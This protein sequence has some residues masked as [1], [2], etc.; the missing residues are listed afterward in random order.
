VPRVEQG[1]RD[2]PDGVREVHDPRVRR[3][4]R[5]H[6]LGDLEDDGHRAHRLR[7]PAC[8]C[9]LLADAA[10]RERDRLVAQPRRLA[11]DPELQEDERGVRDRRVEVVGDGQ[12]AAKALALKHAGRHLPDHGTSLAVDVVQDEL[13][14]GNAVALPRETRDE[15]RRVR[16]AAPDHGELH[17]FT[18]VSVT[19]STNAF[20]AR[21]KTSTTGSIT[22]KVAAIVRFHCTWWRFRNCDN[23]IDVTQLSG[24]SLV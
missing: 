13:V 8:A 3:G 1:A 12:R 23:P 2:D 19:P 7:E 5:P 14:D 11:A 22:S 6:A 9:R 21:K 15:L 18:P 24:F 16:R 20:W 17:P 4:E 10:A